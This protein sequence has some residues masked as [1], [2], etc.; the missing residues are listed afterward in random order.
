[1]KRREGG[2]T[3]APPGDNGREGGVEGRGNTECVRHLDVG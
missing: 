3:D 2:A 1:M